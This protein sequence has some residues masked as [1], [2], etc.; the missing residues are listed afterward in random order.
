MTSLRYSVCPPKD[1]P[2]SPVVKDPKDPLSSP[3]LPH[4][5]SLSKDFPLTPS[6][7]PRSPSLSRTLPTS[8]SIPLSPRFSKDLPLSL[9][10]SP[11][12]S[13]TTKTLEGLSLS[14]EGVAPLRALAN[15]PAKRKLLSR[16]HRGQYFSGPQ[17]WLRGHS[18]ESHTGSLSEGVYTKQLDPD[19][20]LPGDLPSL[21]GTTYVSHAS[22]ILES[23]K[24]RH[25]EPRPHVRRIFVE[26]CKELSP[27]HER[28]G[29]EEEETEEVMAAGVS[30][31]VAQ[32]ESGGE[33]EEPEGAPTQE[34]DSDDQTNTQVSEI[35]S[36]TL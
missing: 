23:R 24:G 5:P 7:L 35:L 19:L 4:S 1:L 2:L 22:C 18:G 10:L 8:P 33:G 6:A 20:P 16:S 36:S 3:L 11:A 29:W 32:V 27:G 31:V 28:R 13:D 9:P 12:L 26:P 17:R 14:K 25:R 21:Q 34:V 15:P 30:V